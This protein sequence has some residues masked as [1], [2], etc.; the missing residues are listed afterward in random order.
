MAIES[1]SGMHKDGR[2]FFLTIPEGKSRKEMLN[3]PDHDF[4]GELFKDKVKRLK[5]YH[6]GKKE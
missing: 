2:K 4:D 5:E 1:I 3:T 6:S